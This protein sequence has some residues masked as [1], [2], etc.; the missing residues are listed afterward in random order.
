MVISFLG[1]ISGQLLLVRDLPFLIKGIQII[2]VLS[3]AG[4]VLAT[5]WSLWPRVFDAPPDA[6]EWRAY[7]QG[8]EKQFAGKDNASDLVA[9]EFS[10]AMSDLRQERI[11]KNRALAVSKS[12]LN[13]WA[14]RATVIAASAQ[15]V[16]LI[17]LAA[18]HL[19][20]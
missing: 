4:G 17:W 12:N 20:R 13:D 8:L 6:A 7:L 5:L 1:A 18:W 19:L 16:S 2:A 11:A 15:A 9:K 14:F 10:A 3:L